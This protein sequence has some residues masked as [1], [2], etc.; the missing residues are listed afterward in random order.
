MRSVRNGSKADVSLIPNSLSYSA[1]PV[2]ALAHAF[3]THTEF[4]S[5]DRLLPLPS[6]PRAR[7]ERG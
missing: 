4:G 5:N 6:A 3:P 1:A 2:L 7:M